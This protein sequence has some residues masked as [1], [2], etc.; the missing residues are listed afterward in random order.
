MRLF[1]AIEIEP[2]LARALGEVSAELR[3]R[4]ESRAPRARL[5]WVPVERLHLTVRFIGEVDAEQAAA[6]G[7]ALAPE[8]PVEPFDLTLREIGTFPPRAAPRVIWV[9]VGGGAEPMGA[10]EREVTRRLASCGIQPEQRGYNP[11]L[12]LARVR[13]AGGL[14]QSD[15]VDPGPAPVFGATRVGAITLFESRLSQKG[16]AYIPLQQTGLGRT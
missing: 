1:T 9:G 3:R 10:I 8:L 14:R 2:A 16:P 5:T 4:V 15:V 12:T 11:H 6:I 7:R 13:D